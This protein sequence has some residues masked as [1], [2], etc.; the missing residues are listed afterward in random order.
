MVS[1]LGQEPLLI[2]ARTF[3]R[4]V[5]GQLQETTGPAEGQDPVAHY[6]NVLAGKTGSLIAASGQYGSL[7]GGAPRDVI[8]MLVE[9]G[10][11]VGLA[12]QLADDIIDLT[13]HD[14]VSGKTPGTDL[15]EG[16]DTLPVL[17]LRRDAEC[18]D[19]SVADPAREVLDLID[20]DLSS[21]DALARAVAAV[22]A[23]PVS[24]EAWDTAN[25][26]ADDAIAAIRPLP[27]TVTKAALIEFAH[28]VVHREG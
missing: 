28:A 2:Q 13:G 20:G 18:E 5:I 3:E 27:E 10:E 9:Y 11:K 17:L 19:R 7:L 1:E 4:L 25:R 21:D 22:T 8:D 15:R 12:F 23:H 16:V 14:D 6:L 26:W 24:A